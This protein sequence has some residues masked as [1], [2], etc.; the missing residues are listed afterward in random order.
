VLN[1]TVLLQPS[2][3]SSN[4]PLKT[5]T[6]KLQLAVLPLASVAVQVTVVVPTAKQVPDGG[7]QATVT[8]GQL[9]LA[10]GVVNV[11]VLQAESSVLVLTTMLAG[12]API[13]GGCVSLTVA[14]KLQV[15]VC[16]S[17]DLAV[18]C[19]VVV[20]TENML[21]D[22]GFPDTVTGATPPEVVAL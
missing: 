4:L 22:A 1:N 7:E 18:T 13:C 19:T 6:V 17:P 2:A 3:S 16:P 15:A 12:Q 20:P 5:D 21:P 14:V 8:P 10:V 9:S 11:T